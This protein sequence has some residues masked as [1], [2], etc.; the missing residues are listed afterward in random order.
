MVHARTPRA[1]LLVLNDTYYPGWKATVDGRP[2]PVERVDYVLRGVPLTR[3]A[4]TVE[5]RY[6]PLTWRVGGVVSAIATI[7]LAAAAA[8][9]IRR[10]RRPRTPR[11]GPARDIESRQPAPTARA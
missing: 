5:L 3:G 8:V 4:H 7:A 1:G 10:R 2:A 11:L 9:G 6:Q